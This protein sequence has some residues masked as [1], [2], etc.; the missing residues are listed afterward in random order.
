[1]RDLERGEFAIAPAAYDL[2][3]DFFY[4]QRDLF[5]AIREGVREGGAF[6]GAILLETPEGNPAF[7][8]EPGQLREEFAG[9]KIVYYSETGETARII[10]RRA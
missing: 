4:L 10:A 5:A 7:S 9:W 6:I 1:M 2:I 8:L 3:C